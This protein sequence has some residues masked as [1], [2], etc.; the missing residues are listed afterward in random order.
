[1]VQAVKTSIAKKLL[2]YLYLIS[3]SVAAFITVA[4][5]YFD[6][7]RESKVLQKD[8]DQLSDIASKGISAL[9]WNRDSE[10]ITNQLNGILENPMAFKIEV[11]DDAGA[12]Q[13]SGEAKT[14]GKPKYAF[15]KSADIKY[16]EGN[17]PKVIGRIDFVMS[18]DKVVDGVLSRFISVLCLNALKAIVVS[19]MLLIVL[20][21][22]ITRPVDEMVKYFRTTEVPKDPDVTIQDRKTSYDE[23]SELI[24][25]LQERE[26][27]LAEF[28]QKNILTIAAQSTEIAERQEQLAAERER[29][30][31]NARMAQLGE[32]AAG[33]AHEI[34]NP[35]TI[36]VGHSLRAKNALKKSPPD[37]ERITEALEKIEATTSRIGKITHGL[38][39]Y[40]RD[41]RKDPLTAANAT[42][43]VT[44]AIEM[45]SARAAADEIKLTCKLSW[46]ANQEIDCRGS[47]LSQVLVI[48]INNAFDAIRGTT[49]GWI[50]LGGQI[51]GRIL[52][53][54][55]TDSGTGIPLDVEKK[56]FEPFFTTKAVGEGTGLGLSVAFGL[57]KYHNGLIFVNR[58]SPNTQ[59]VIK[60]PLV[61]A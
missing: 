30:E 40:S 27:S 20:R 22:L 7:T 57:I 4:S 24:D 51:E 15:N 44:T 49:G 5:S 58:D 52:S 9:L 12:S 28:N 53:L 43:I 11:F 14:R 3:T 17:G 38:L 48:L 59:F 41:G 42:E 61:H 35:L 31:M 60:L 29:A 39:T 56:I 46:L 55:I 21:R 6:Y 2:L 33:L 36:I 8:A 25:Y 37:L 13:F 19:T 23:I 47:Q 54:T 32:L 18:E 45:Y 34:N 1:M 26:R 16:D 10:S 50:E